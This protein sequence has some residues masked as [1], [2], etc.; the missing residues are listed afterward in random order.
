MPSARVRRGDGRVSPARTTTLREFLHPIRRTAMQKW[1]PCARPE[2]A[3]FQKN[4]EQRSYED[5]AADP[6]HRW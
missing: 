1:Q 2:R 5:L 3:R 4:V 6:I